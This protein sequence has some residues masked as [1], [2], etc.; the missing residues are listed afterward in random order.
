VGRE[1]NSGSAKVA[2]SVGD[3]FQP[4]ERPQQALLGLSQYSTSPILRPTHTADDQ[5]DGTRLSQE[6]KLK[7]E[8]LKRLVNKYTQYH[9]NPDGIIKWAVQCAINGD[10][11][12]LDEKSEQ[13]RSIDNF[14]RK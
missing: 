10:N 12:F 5:R 11:R 2:D 6:T 8:E 9:S 3:T 14:D 4:R 7:I 1:F 13:L